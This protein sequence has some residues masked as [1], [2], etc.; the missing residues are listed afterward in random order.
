MQTLLERMGP[1]L[2]LWRA[3]E[4]AALREQSYRAP[5]L[6]I[7]CGDGIV[8]AHVLSAVDIGVDPDR[9]ALAKAARQGIYRQLI[10]IAVEEAPLPAACIRTVVSN[11]VLEHLP[12]LDLVLAA[13]ARVLRPG[14]KFIFTAPTE[15]FAKWLA[16]P[17]TRYAAWRNRQLG[18]LNLWSLEC[19]AERLE[20]AGFEFLETRCYLRRHWV[21]LWD[22][23]ELAQMVWVS[24]KRLVGVLWKRLS[25][26]WLNRLA[27]WASTLDLG[28]DAEGGGRMIVAR[29]L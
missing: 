1:S 18:H 28:A 17:S 26:N 6:D 12:Q 25:M 5:I 2:G 20:Q 10:P 21:F 15:T 9:N 27:Q 24:R 7:G 22:A 4:V 19:W 11:S 13:V 3:A 29:K 23:L 8:T 14:G 16:I